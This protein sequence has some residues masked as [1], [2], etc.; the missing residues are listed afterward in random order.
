MNDNDVLFKELIHNHLPGL[1][2]FAKQWD[3]DAA[4]DI[5][6]EAFIKLMRQKVLPD[7]PAAW[8]FTV[9]RNDSN[10]Y[11]RSLKRRKN[12]ELV[13]QLQKPVWFEKTQ[14]YD[15][16]GKTDRLVQELES[17]ELE[18]REIIVAKIWGGLSFDK[19][20]EMLGSSSSSVH[21]KYQEGLNRLEQRVMS[22]G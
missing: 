13:S 9:V 10:N 12:R 22:R 17:L 3:G 20:A 19:I 1:V 11:V 5:V 14:E 21:R 2:L 8:L 6:Q 16:I 15:E 4:E 7:N 18:Y